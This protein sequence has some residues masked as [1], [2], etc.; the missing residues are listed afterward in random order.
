MHRYKDKHKNETKPSGWIYIKENKGNFTATLIRFNQNLN[1][2][3]IYVFRM[4]IYLNVL[5]FANFCVRKR[6]KSE[7]FIIY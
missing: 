3:K 4:Q 1:Y 6:S 5:A 7:S 2:E